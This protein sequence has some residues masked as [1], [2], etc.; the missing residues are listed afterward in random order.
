[1]NPEERAVEP[2]GDAS[3]SRTRTPA[4]LAASA[5]TR[6]QAPAPTTTTGIFTRWSGACDS[7]WSA[8]GVFALRQ[9]EARALTG[10]PKDD[11]IVQCEQRV[12][13]G[14]RDRRILDHP[15]FGEMRAKQGDAGRGLLDDDR[16]HGLER[17]AK[18]FVCMVSARRRV[19]HGNRLVDERFEAHQPIEGVLDRAGD[20]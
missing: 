2:E 5:A 12:P 15:V 11:G 9:R 10:L 17:L 4:F 18:S 3:R 1:M 13:N 16:G 7:T 19:Q 8:R 14:A 20:A 6:P